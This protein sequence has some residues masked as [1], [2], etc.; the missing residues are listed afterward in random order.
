MER[1]NTLPYMYISFMAVI[2]QVLIITHWSS[3]LLGILGRA[4][5][6]SQLDTW[7][8]KFGLCTP[9]DPLADPALVSVPLSASMKASCM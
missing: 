7:Q 4:A 2:S 5:A 3:C 8:A 1:R 6:P 9:G